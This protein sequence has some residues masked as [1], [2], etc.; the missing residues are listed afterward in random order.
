MCTYSLPQVRFL[1]YAFRQ[2]F[3]CCLPY[4]IKNLISQA[5]LRSPGN[6][7]VHFDITNTGPAHTN[8]PSYGDINLIYKPEILSGTITQ[9]ITHR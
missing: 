3:Q 5:K 9:L 7:V 1:E 2:S 8:S 6:G 4:N